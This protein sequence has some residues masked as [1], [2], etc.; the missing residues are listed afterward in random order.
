MH[1]K[2]NS[3]E[4]NSG[5]FSAL[6]HKTP[7]SMCQLTTS[8]PQLQS[9]PRVLI[10]QLKCFMFTPAPVKKTL[11]DTRH[12][13][14]FPHLY[15]HLSLNF[16]IAILRLFLCHLLVN[17]VFAFILKCHNILGEHY[18]EFIL[19]LFIAHILNSCRMSF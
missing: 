3:K 5:P 8:R 14:R 16:F 10:W 18:I 1:L 11:P 19:Q 13:L 7:N 9:H 6:I 2:Q 15:V 17:S 4:T 12:H